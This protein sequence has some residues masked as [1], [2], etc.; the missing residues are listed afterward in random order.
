MSENKEKSYLVTIEI[1][2]DEHHYDQYFVLRCVGQEEAV[3]LAWAFLRSGFYFN[4][5]LD[6]MDAVEI[7][8]KAHAVV[9]PFDSERWHTVTQVLELPEELTPKLL[10][11]LPRSISWDAT[12]EARN[13][14]EELNKENS[15]AQ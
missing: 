10:G 7:D 13:A 11:A 12:E 2:Q 15:H 14:L 1:C 3:R 9:E 4:V 5:D 6:L 8:E